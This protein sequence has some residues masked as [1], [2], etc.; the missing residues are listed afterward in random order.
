MASKGKIS[1]GDHLT[2]CGDKVFRCVVIGQSE[3]LGG[4]VKYL[5]K[6]RDRFG[7]VE[8]WMSAEEIA[9][10]EQLKE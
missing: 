9:A 8:E 1:L 4:A 10:L 3:Y 6:W 5:L 7:F 2:L